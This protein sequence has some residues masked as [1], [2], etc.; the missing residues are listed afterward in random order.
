MMKIDYA[1]FQNRVDYSFKKEILLIEALTHKSFSIEEN[2]NQ[3]HNERLE[4]LGD[5]VLN[6]VIAAD[7]VKQFPADAEGLLSKKRASLVNQTTLAEISKKLNLTKFIKFGPGEVK[8]GSPSNPRILASAVEA[9]IG[10]I[11]LDSDYPTV[12]HWVL[13]L[14]KD[15]SSEQSEGISNAFDF[16]TRLQE[17]TQKHKLGTP[18]YE[19]LITTG[20]SHKPHF[21]VSLQL[22]QIE[23]SR[24]EGASKKAAEQLAAEIYLKEL[25]SSRPQVKGEKHGI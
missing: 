14:F 15:I 21:L 25:I 13:K 19:V 2:K 9:L 12:E 20:P 1:E 6:F 16:K 8:Q 11:F 22:N 18:T 4:F 10:A 24:A 5:S 23:K 17:L 7:L 3:R